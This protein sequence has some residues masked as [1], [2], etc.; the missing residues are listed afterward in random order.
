MGQL[1]EDGKSYDNEMT[2]NARCRNYSKCI[3]VCSL[4]ANILIETSL[5]SKVLR[6]FLVQLFQ[7]LFF[8]LKQLQEVQTCPHRTLEPTER[9]GLD[10]QIELLQTEQYFFTKYRQPSANTGQ[11]RRHIVSPCNQHQ[12]FMFLHQP[13]EF[14]QC[15]DGFHPNQFQ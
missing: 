5:H 1:N 13:R 7:T 9:I 15:G 14:I 10:E 11:L 2:S 3:V 6:N 4:A 12:I 8:P